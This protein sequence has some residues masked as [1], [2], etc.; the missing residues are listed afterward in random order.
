[1]SNWSDEVT[2]RTESLE[3]QKKA[4]LENKDIWLRTDTLARK[5]KANQNIRNKIREILN[6]I[7]RAENLSINEINNSLNLQTRL[8]K[9]IVEL[10]ETIKKI[11]DLLLAKKRE[12]FVRNAP[13]IWESISGRAGLSIYD[14]R[15]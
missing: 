3:E 11:D 4:L 13:P 2:S 15:V 10:D 8:S 5:E 12:I 7:S 6:E 1:M 14:Q 9:E